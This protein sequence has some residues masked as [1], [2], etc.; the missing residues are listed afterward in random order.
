MSVVALLV[1]GLV[2]LAGYAVGAQSRAE[3]GSGDSA[4]YRGDADEGWPGDAEMERRRQLLQDR[5]AA[6]D[7]AVR[8]LLAKRFTLGEAAA[9]L[10][11]I[12]EEMPKTWGPLVTAGVPGDGEYLCRRVIAAANNWVAR[13]LPEAAEMVNTRLEAEL[14]Q[15]RGPDGAIRLPD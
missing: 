7:Y 15:L 2:G 12:E 6:R 9:R 5:V 14:Q 11:N 4:V 8:E 1:A 13:N 3:R 10:R